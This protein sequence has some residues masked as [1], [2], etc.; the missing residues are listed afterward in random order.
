MLLASCT[1]TYEL[2][3]YMSE[4]SSCLYPCVETLITL[5]AVAYNKRNKLDV[6]S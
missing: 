6:R 2:K 1:A 5:V 4:E 3:C